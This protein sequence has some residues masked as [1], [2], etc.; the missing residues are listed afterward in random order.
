MAVSEEQI[1]KVARKILIARPKMASV[2]SLVYTF[3]KDYQLVLDLALAAELW[4]K[5]KG[6][7]GNPPTHD[8]STGAPL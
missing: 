7:A 5:Y 4:R 6:F 1:D 2:G 3:K 8:V